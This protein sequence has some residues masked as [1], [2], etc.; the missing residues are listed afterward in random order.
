MSL[1]SMVGSGDDS[2]LK[3]IQLK[4]KCVWGHSCGELEPSSFHPFIHWLDRCCMYHPIKSNEGSSSE[5]V[6]TST[7]LFLSLS[8][9]KCPSRPC[10]GGCTTKQ[11]SGFR[12]RSLDGIYDLTPSS[13]SFLA[14]MTKGRPISKC[15]NIDRSLDVPPNL[16]AYHHPRLKHGLSRSI[17][18]I[19]RVVCAQWSRII[20][21]GTVGFLLTQ[22]WSS[23]HKSYH[24]SP[25][26]GWEHVRI[27]SAT[28]T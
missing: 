13:R 12:W 27:E 18:G 24:S 10:F 19:V 6:G 16:R 1:S 15:G 5:E 9:I 17:L 25:G 4:D 7:W 14:I 22:K 26:N 20:Y 8:T 3:P 28:Y 11:L 23:G 21:S 2:S